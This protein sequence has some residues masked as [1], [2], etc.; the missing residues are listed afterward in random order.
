MPPLMLGS[1]AFLRKPE[2]SSALTAN[3]EKLTT[4]SPV[5]PV[6][7]LLGD[8]QANTPTGGQLHH[9]CIWVSGGYGDGG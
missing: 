2:C 3:I 4:I 7:S 5:A 8:D 9:R 6:I 1:K